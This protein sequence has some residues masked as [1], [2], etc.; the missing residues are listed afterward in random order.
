M[1]PSDFRG[2]K[3]YGN[4]EESSFCLGRA[5]AILTPYSLDAARSLAYFNANDTQYLGGNGLTGTLETGSINK[6]AINRLAHF[7][8]N[9]YMLAG[10]SIY[11]YDE[12]SKTWSVSLW[13]ADKA[14]TESN[15]IGLYPVMIGNTPSLITAFNTTGA[16]WQAVILNGLTDIWASG[17]TGTV[18]NPNDA[19]GGILNEVQH[20]NKIYFIDSNVSNIGWYDF[21]LDD[22]G[23]IPWSDTV[24]H[25]MDFVTY[26]SGLYCLNKDASRNINL[27]RIDRDSTTMVGNPIILRSGSQGPDGEQLNAALSTISNLEARNLLFVDNVRVDASGKPVLWAINM[28][29]ADTEGTSSSDFGATFT[30]LTLDNN[31]NFTGVNGFTPNASFMSNPFKMMH[32]QVGATDDFIAKPESMVMRMYIDQR[33]REVVGE[34]RIHCSTRFGGY[35]G[36]QPSANGSVYAGGGGDFNYLVNWDWLGGGAP[37]YPLGQWGGPASWFFIQGIKEAR[38]RSFPHEKIGGGARS[39]VLLPDGYKNI[40]IVYR[41]SQTTDQSGV[42]R[43]FYNLITTSGVPNGTNVSVKWFYDDNLHAPE[44]QCTPVGTS[45]GAVSGLQVVS[46]PADSGTIF[47]FDWDAQGDGLRY[48]SRINLNGLVSTSDISLAALNDPTDLGGLTLWLEADDDTTISSGVGDKVSEWR[49]KSGYTGDGAISGVSQ[50]TAD[51]QPVVAIAAN[52]SLDGMSFDAASGHY[53]FTSG[54]PILYESFTTFMIFEPNSAG[55][56]QTAFSISAD[57][58]HETLGP[59]LPSGTVVTDGEFYSIETS[60]DFGSVIMV[61][62]DIYRTEEATAARELPLTSGVEV[63][64][65]KLIWWR[66]EGFRGLAN[67]HPNGAYPSG[68]EQSTEFS[69]GMVTPSGLSNASG[70]ISLGNTTVGRFSGAQ[71]SGVYGSAG[72]YYDGIIYEI[73]AY[74]RKLSDIEIDRFVLYASGKYSLS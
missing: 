59:D 15:S 60:G 43:I 19:N 3:A 25:P 70:T 4:S 49:D 63:G 47:Y 42:M 27:H 74:N 13:L 68:L 50:V 2:N 7:M 11:I 65:A 6:Q 8:N 61:S 51:V 1:G 58:S 40:D 35:C 28:S 69:D 48:G 17:L 38:H 23:T 5:E 9:T 32:N 67:F 45:H 57:D 36:G 53:L 22:F 29:H 21:Q 44:S 56:R 73:A 72:Q 66:E 20:K 55:S 14:G 18:F 34:T 71:T 64:N 33:E 37:G 62:Q 39:S 54:A 26:Q 24:L 31:D 16:T 52:N 30:A 46:L 12:V 41:G 10:D